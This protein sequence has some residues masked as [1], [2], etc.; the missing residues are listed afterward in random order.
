[1]RQQTFNNKKSTLYL[2]A[3][4]IGNLG[5]FS[6]RAIETLRNVSLIACEDTRQT[7]N[8]LLTLK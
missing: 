5:D 1:M 7:K 8:L 3:T 4:P 6:T 2:T